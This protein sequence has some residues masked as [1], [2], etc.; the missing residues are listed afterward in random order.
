MQSRTATILA[1]F[2]AAPL[3]LAGS[4]QACGGT[5]LDPQPPVI[6]RLQIETT[7]VTP[8]LTISMSAVVRGNG[9]IVYAW[10][11]RRDDGIEDAGQFTEPDSDATEWTAPFDEGTVEI[12]LNVR[13]TRGIAETAISILVGPGPDGDGDGFAVTAGD[14]DDQNAAIF[15]GAPELP[16]AIDNDCDGL[17]DEGSEEVDDDVDGFSDIQGDCD[18]GDAAVYPG[19]PEQLNGLDDDCDGEIDD[20]TTEYDDDGDGFTES[21]GDCNDANASIRPSAVEL[22]DG[23]D[24][25]CDSVVD[26]NTVGSDDDLDGFSELAGDCNDGDNDTYPGADELPDSEDND[27]NGVVDDGS[28][29][30]DDDGDGWTG[31]SGDCNDSNPYTYPGAP[32]YAD[33]TDNDCDGQVDEGMDG[34]D[35]DGDGFDESEGDCNDA[36]AAIYP[37]SLELDDGIDNDCDGAGYTNPPIASASVLPGAEAC[38]PVTLTAENSYD[39]DGD[40]LDFTWFFTAKPSLSQL[41]DADIVNRFSMIASFTPDAAGYFAVGLQVTDGA[42]TSAPAT[43]GFTVAPRPGNS[44]PT[45]AFVGNNINDLA[46]T[47][48]STDAYGNCTSCPACSRTYTVDARASSDLDGDALTYIW[49]AQKVSGAGQPPSVTD[50]GNGTATVGLQVSTTCGQSDSGLFE[51]EV[52]VHDCNGAVDSTTMQI[53]FTCQS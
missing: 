32:E 14:C 39:P 45:A 11:S 9:N 31:L 21:E 28:F 10:S 46:T 49:S 5:A 48:C 33:G 35:N 51:V 24:N 16:D 18:D 44:T 50:N 29:I 27:C 34:S 20:N 2:V 40:T 47:T 1:A 19:A 41:D 3:L 8:G 6:E 53:N 52:Q 36:N 37:G 38:A 26:E 42:F 17:V 7:N 4:M 15:P 12:V 30:S 23:V 25:D 13:D 43:V 22:L